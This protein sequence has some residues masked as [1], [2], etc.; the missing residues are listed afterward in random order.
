MLSGSRVCDLHAQLR[1]SAWNWAQEQ[2]SSPVRADH[3]QTCGGGLGVDATQPRT[4][5]WTLPP[6]EHQARPARVKSS[7]NFAAA[8]D[9]PVASGCHAESHGRRAA[10]QRC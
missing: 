4:N 1:A 5:L 8:A 6:M 7:S 10:D 9:A 2:G 3:I